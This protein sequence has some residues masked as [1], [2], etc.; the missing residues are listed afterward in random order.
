MAK[1]IK[2]INT[3][4]ITP[5]KKRCETVDLKNLGDQEEKLF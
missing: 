5:N 3:L 4:T 2:I 1:D